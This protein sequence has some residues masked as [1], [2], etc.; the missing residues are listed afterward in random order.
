MNHETV[1]ILDFGAQYAQLIARRVRE[2]HCYCEIL[3]CT[4]D[5]ERLEGAKGIILTGGPASVYAD[6]APRCDRRVFELRELDGLEY[7]EIADRLGVPIGTVRSRLNRA[8]S[9][10]REGLEKT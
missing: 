7:A 9:A 4:V 10:L 5:P 2:H 3:P 8:R 1:Y 6:G